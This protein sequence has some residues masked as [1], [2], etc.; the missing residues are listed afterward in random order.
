MLR[1]PNCIRCT[2]SD[3]QMRKFA[4]IALENAFVIPLLLGNSDNCMSK[5]CPL[6]EAGA[7]LDHAPASTYSHLIVT[8]STQGVPGRLRN[9]MR[10]SAL[11]KSLII[12]EFLED[13][14]PESQHEHHHLLNL[15]DGALWTDYVKQ[16]IL[17]YIRLISV[18]EAQKP[19][20]LLE[21]LDKGTPDALSLR[22]CV[23]WY[24]SS[25]S[26]SRSPTSR[27]RRVLPRTGSWRTIE[28]AIARLWAADGLS[29]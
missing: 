1:L 3:T 12:C 25:G 13:A 16:V 22:K 14:F 29:T 8:R 19:R 24:E 18:Q 17:V 28:G 27:L 10:G 11:H 23:G 26:S 5:H 20:A 9:R 2:D 15:L 6:V 21:R 4:F 7:A